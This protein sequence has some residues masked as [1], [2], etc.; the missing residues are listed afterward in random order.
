MPSLLTLDADHRTISDSP[1]CISVQGDTDRK[2]GRAIVPNDLNAADCLAAGPLS[3]GLQALFPE[4]SVAHS[5]RFEFRHLKQIM[6]TKG[7]ATAGKVRRR[8][9]NRPNEETWRNPCL[10]EP[11]HA[12]FRPPNFQCERPGSFSVGRQHGPANSDSPAAF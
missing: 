11:L 9:E 4:S 6:E 2:A 3:N 12:R 10:G 1:V 5:D 8:Q 7:A